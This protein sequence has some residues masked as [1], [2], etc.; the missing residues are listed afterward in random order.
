MVGT[1]NQARIP[2]DPQ[3]AGGR[4]P[5]DPVQAGL[6]AGGRISENPTTAEAQKASIT[7]TNP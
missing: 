2:V 4:I 3:Q 7:L 6:G 5:V 1:G